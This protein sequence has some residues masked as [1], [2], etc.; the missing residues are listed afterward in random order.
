VGGG[1]DDERA[2][3]GYDLSHRNPLQSNLRP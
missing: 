2:Q 3:Q 1:H